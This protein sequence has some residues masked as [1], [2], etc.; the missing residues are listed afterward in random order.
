[1]ALS[2]KTKISK[3]SKHRQLMRKVRLL[4]GVEDT[5]HITIEHCLTNLLFLLFPRSF[6]LLFSIVLH[7]LCLLHQ[8]GA[9]GSVESPKID[10]FFGMRTIQQKIKSGTEIPVQKF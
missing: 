5:A 3:L 4:L 7:Q 8:V 1:V 10:N 9:Q 6:F 2:I